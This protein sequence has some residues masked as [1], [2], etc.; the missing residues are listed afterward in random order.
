M[1]KD[2]TMHSCRE[3]VSKL[4]SSAPTPGGG[5]AAALVGAVGVALGQMVGN[6]TVGKRK[7]AAVEE[8]VRMLMTECAYLQEELLNQVMADAEGFE[9]LARAYGIPK[10]DPT[11]DEVL[12]AAAISACAVPL[13]I[14]ELCCKAIK[15]MVALAEKG[16]RLAASDVGCGA[17]FCKAALQAASLN[18]FINTAGVRD[19]TQAEE[20]NN[21]ANDM[22]SRYCDLADR[23]FNAVSGEF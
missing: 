21:R 20:L 11:R 1:A 15:I 13:R 8:E 10:D 7:Y 23:V 16:S 9:P 12:E 2:Y 3:F 19:R 18:V 4:A 6:L 22:L 14:M 17:V 5:G